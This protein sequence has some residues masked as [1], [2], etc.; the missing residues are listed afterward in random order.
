MVILDAAMAGTA[1]GATPRPASS[2]PAVPTASAIPR[3]WR[4]RAPLHET[5]GQARLGV[6][7]QPTPWW[8]KAVTLTLTLAYRACNAWRRSPAPAFRWAPR[9]GAAAPGV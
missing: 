3:V 8:N 7:A 9:R 5:A 6:M 4:M 1:A 2:N